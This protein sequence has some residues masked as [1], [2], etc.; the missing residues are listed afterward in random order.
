MSEN[1]FWRLTCGVNYDRE[2]SCGFLAKQKNDE[3]AELVDD[4]GEIWEL[5]EE[6]GEEGLDR[7]SDYV[8]ENSAW[9]FLH[10]EE[11]SEEEFNNSDNWEEPSAK[12]IAML[13]QGDDEDDEYE[14][15]DDEC[16]CE[17][18]E[19]DCEDEDDEEDDEEEE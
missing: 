1:K 9:A 10:H 14:G 7:Y 5:Y 15:D 8:R 18:G 17:Y 19:C 2:F 16:D 13:S 6:E 12:K 3:E 11:I 4:C